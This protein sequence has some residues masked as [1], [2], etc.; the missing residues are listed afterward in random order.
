MVASELSARNGRN[1]IDRTS[2]DR[3][4]FGKKKLVE[5]VE[6]SVHGLRVARVISNVSVDQTE[7]VN[8]K[9]VIMKLINFSMEKLDV[10]NNSVLGEMCIRDRSCTMLH[11]PQARTFR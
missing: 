11:I 5:P 8:Q 10:P 3:S 2:I 1:N 6:L 7:K 4:S 9:S